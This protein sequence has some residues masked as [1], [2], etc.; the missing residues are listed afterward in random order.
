MDTTVYKQ[1]R[2]ISW[3]R[4]NERV[5]EEAN[6]VDVPLLERLKF[7]SIFT[8]NLDEFFMIRVG[9]L[10]DMS[11]LKK[12]VIDN[13]TG[14]NST[15]QIKHILAMLPAM[16]IKRDR[17]YHHL[18]DDLAA[19]NIFLLTMASLSKTERKYVIKYYRTMLH[20]LISPQIIDMNHPFPFLDNKKTYIFAELMQN[21]KLL[22]GLL[23]IRQSFPS[24]LVL[25]N[26][27][28]FRYILMEDILF[29]M[30]D[31]IFSDFKILHKYRLS[32]TRNFDLES[33]R[34]SK[35]EFD[36]YR[37]Y[38]K[39]LLKKRRRLSPVRLETN[40]KL[41]KSAQLF[42]L[43]KLGLHPTEVFVSET[44]LSM[45]Y[46]FSLM[47]EIPENMSRPLLYKPFCAYNPFPEKS[48][49]IDC[50]R[51]KDMLLS[52]PYDDIDGFV[53]LL[54]EASEH[55]DCLAIKIT[56]YRLAKDSKIVRYLC[57]AAERGIDVTVFL[58]LKARFDEENNINYSDILYESG[59]TILYGFSEYKIHS[60][61]MSLTFR[62]KKNGVYF[63]TQIGTGN[64]NEST[65]RQY[66]DF[67]LITAHPEIGQDANLFFKNMSMG[68]LDGTYRH[69]LQSPTGLKPKLLQL[70]D[71]EI[72]KGED[73]FIFCKFNSLTDKD[74]IEK[75]SEAS[76]NSCP[77][78]LII[79]GISC[80]LPGV[81]QKTDH[82][83]IHSIVGRFLEHSRVYVFGKDNPDVF[84]SSADLMTRNM[85]RRVEIACPVY[86]PTI[87]ERLLS[88]MNQQWADSIKG[89]RM[90]LFGQYTSLKENEDP[91]DVQERLIR[92]AQDKIRDREYVVP[93]EKPGLFE[94]LIRVFKRH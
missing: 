84:I 72:A 22:Y 4:F 36:D 31:E 59:C 7:I 5:L 6:A 64:Y 40:A 85:E 70:M 26:G 27:P 94:R 19:Q 34:E 17:Y 47:G 68:R 28:G 78:Q 82:I 63:I 30:A 87:K 11:L 41:S 9:S 37:E 92:E 66:T 71:R 18:N 49:L 38:M 61:L 77:V 69:L 21:N 76:R 56:I 57:R 2:E 81:P 65:S 48:S 83:E 60:K 74:F 32:V 15:D 16:Y 24:Y 25:P 44:P 55:P 51:K 35:D 50:V 45:R 62:D 10:H 53:D 14:M 93:Q 89:R 79:R 91:Y 23:P 29:A 52:Y 73:G 13:K 43:D 88:Y 75:F 1:N 33:D 3:L 12:P 67:S 90:D 46:V 80:L 8:S 58:E 42:L 54:K 20:D 86:D 39:A